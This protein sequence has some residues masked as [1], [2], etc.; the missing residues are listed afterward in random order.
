MSARRQCIE[1][2]LRVHHERLLSSVVLTTQLPKEKA[3]RAVVAM[4]P[5]L[6]SIG[7]LETW[8][9]NRAPTFPAQMLYFLCTCSVSC[10][11]LCILA[12]APEAVRRSLCTGFVD[13]PQ[14]TEAIRFTAHTV[15]F[16]AV[17]D[18]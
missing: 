2:Q 13:T 3:A 4:L 9:G 10:A 11:M 14:D 18:R 15:Y 6:K 5:A 12:V 17:D 1:A 16:D 7:V 8:T